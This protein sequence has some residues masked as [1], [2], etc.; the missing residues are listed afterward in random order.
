MK[1]RLKSV[2]QTLILL[3]ILAISFGGPFVALALQMDSIDDV[4]YQKDNN[5]LPV[6]G[7]LSSDEENIWKL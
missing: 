4:N 3:N 2:I 7:K 5:S 1:F 6:Q